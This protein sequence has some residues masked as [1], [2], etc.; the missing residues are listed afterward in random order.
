MSSSPVTVN[1]Y[2]KPNGGS[3]RRIAPQNMSLAAGALAIE[4]Q[5]VTMGAGD[6]ILGDASAVSAVDWVMSGIQR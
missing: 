3:V 1:L 4:D 5:E 6:Q 2:F